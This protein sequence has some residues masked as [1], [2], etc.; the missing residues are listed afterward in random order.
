M[1]SRLET[2]RLG[3]ARPGVLR[4]HHTGQPN[5]RGHRG[6]PVLRRLVDAC[7]AGRLRY[8]QF[9][10]HRSEVAGGIN[11]C[12][13]PTPGLVLSSPQRSTHPSSNTQPG[14]RRPTPA[15]GRWIP[16]LCLTSLRRMVLCV[17]ADSSSLS[18]HYGNLRR[19]SLIIS[20]MVG[21]PTPGFKTM[22]PRL[23]R[24]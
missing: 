13:A 16:H 11:R 18:R 7:N 12:G 24:F 1:R 15:A 19:R 10:P 2:A 22:A 21:I 14:P 17:S 6:N 23:N 8:E 5:E 3:A 20:A 4:A 9:P